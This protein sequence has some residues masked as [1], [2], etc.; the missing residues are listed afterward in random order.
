MINFE[1][2]LRQKRLIKKI[3]INTNLSSDTAH[4]YIITY[5]NRRGTLVALTRSVI[6][7]YE[8][9]KEYKVVTLCNIIVNPLFQRMNIGS[10]I[11]N[12]TIQHFIDE[13]DAISVELHCSPYTPIG[14]FTNYGYDS[15][16]I[17]MQNTLKFYRK[18]GFKVRSPRTLYS[19]IFNH[20]GVQMVKHLKKQKI[21]SKFARSKKI[22][23]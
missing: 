23:K 3:R 8:Y 7:L 18:N 16:S 15:I 13:Y 21:K 10:H 12:E 17:G 19:D 6:S 14:N 11:L 5:R 2:F 22:K 9:S 1:Q 4:W 20:D